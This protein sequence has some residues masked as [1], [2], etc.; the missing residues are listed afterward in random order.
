MLEGTADSRVGEADGD[1]TEGACVEFWM[2]L[3][4]VEGALG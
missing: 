1:C 2:S 4:D 3:H